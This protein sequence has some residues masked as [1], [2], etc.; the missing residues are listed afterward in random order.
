M[1]VQ[2]TA[3]CCT[4]SIFL[5]HPNMH[6]HSLFCPSSQNSP[7]LL[8]NKPIW[9]HCCCVCCF[10]ELGGGCLSHQ[11]FIP[12]QNSCCPLQG[13]FRDN[14]TI[15]A[16]SAVLMIVCFTTDLFD[17]MFN[18]VLTIQCVNFVF[19][20]FLYLLLMVIFIG[21]SHTFEASSILRGLS[22]LDIPYS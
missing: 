16:T 22:R 18:H 15:S 2:P 17:L 5:L 3:N 4:C 14:W 12:F 6:T 21:N 13:D 8:Y 11:P 1:E 9:F 10:L 7:F 20:T 19:I